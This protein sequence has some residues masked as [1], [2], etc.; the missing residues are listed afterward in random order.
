VHSAAF[1]IGHGLL[2]IVIDFFFL[3]GGAVKHYLNESYSSFKRFG[4]EG[5]PYSSRRAS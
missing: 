5:L 2:A 1:N 3:G 4:V